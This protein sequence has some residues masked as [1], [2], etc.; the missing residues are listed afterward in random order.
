[1]F[2]EIA[3]SIADTVSEII[4][5]SV[6]V[7]DENAVIIGC[8]VKKRLGTEHIQS[9]TAMRENKMCITRCDNAT[10]AE[11]SQPGVTL[12]IQFFDKI[13]GAI[14]IIGKP[15]EVER[16]G[17]FAQQQAESMLR[18]QV[19]IES[20]IAKERALRELIDNIADFD[21]SVSMTELINL[22]GRE[23]GVSLSR[24]RVAMVMEL[25][26]WHR[27][28]TPEC[29]RRMLLRDICS[30]FP[31]TG[32][33]ICPHGS[34]SVTI[35]MASVGAASDEDVTKNATVAVR[36]MLKDTDAKGMTVDVAI[37]FPAHNLDGISASLRAAHDAMRI[38][39]R[40]KHGGVIF[41]EDMT[42]EM[43][44]DLLPH[45]RSEEFSDRILSELLK[46][47]DYEEMRDT[48]LGWCET[49]FASGEVAERL[50]LHRNSLQYRLKKIR[51]LTGKDPWNFKDAFEL[52]AA[53]TLKKIS[54]KNRI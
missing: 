26:E 21:G 43:L 12:P 9:M 38:A 4:G 37:G 31:H 51:A 8:S 50:A 23:L 2:S 6:A 25:R 35:L 16:F 14:S 54:T 41:A 32:N 53:F 39:K 7:A 47:S 15:D 17:I 18:E 29:V 5:R 28:E 42:A 49:P 34:R 33:I 19:F 11:G 22:Q 27:G 30:C 24:C 52:W 1:M 45:E 3:Q 10:V 48:F 36:R 46:R 13:I 20:N 44:L 40:L